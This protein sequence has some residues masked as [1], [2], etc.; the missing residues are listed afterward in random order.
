MVATGDARYCGAET[1]LPSAVE[2]NGLDK[3]ASVVG[4]NFQVIGEEAFV[5]KVTQKGIPEVAVE[6]GV[7]IWY[8]AFFEVVGFVLLKFGEQSRDFDGG[9]VWNGTLITRI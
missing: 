4:V 1:D 9:S 5:V 8:F 3:A 2:F 7:E 6:R